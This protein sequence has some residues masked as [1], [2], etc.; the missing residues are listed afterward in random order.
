[1]GFDNGP[2]RPT[3]FGISGAR[4]TSADQS[5][6]VAAVTDAT[7]TGLKLCVVDL[8]VSV[9]TAMRVDFK[10]ETSGTVVAS[11]YLAANTTA[12]VTP[13]GRIKLATAAKKLM[14]QTSA[15]G[16]IA[17]TAAYHFEP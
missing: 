14:V 11:L 15:S 7:G 9:D 17:V 4:F 12:Q 2:S 13:R 6:G 8:I 1:M 10:E 5:A 16:N 3:Q